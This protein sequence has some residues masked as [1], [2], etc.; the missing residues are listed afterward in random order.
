MAVRWRVTPSRGWSGRLFANYVRD[1]CTIVLVSWVPIIEG[2]MKENAPW[3]DRTGN[4]RQWLEAEVYNKTATS[5]AL[6]A[7]GHMTYQRF[8]ELKQKGKSILSPELEQ[9]GKY[10]VILPTIET[11]KKAIFEEI[12]E[13]LGR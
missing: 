5:V 11:H 6:I 2:D 9:A 3:T 1:V 10:A 13:A 12:V 4:A 8:L 7:R